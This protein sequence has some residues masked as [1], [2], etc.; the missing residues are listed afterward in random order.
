MT[1][2]AVRDF[3][4]ERGISAEV[5]AAFSIQPNGSGWTWKTSLWDGGEG[6]R[7]KN[8]LSQRPEG[9]QTWKKYKWLPS[10]PG[11]AI[12]LYPP[13]RSLKE[14]ISRGGGR[15]YLPG[16]EVGVMSFMSAGTWNATSLF[17]DNTIPPNLPNLLRELGVRTLILIPDRD[18]SGET[19]AAKIRDLL[20]PCFDIELEVRALPY[21]FEAKHGL[22]TNDLWL[23]VLDTTPEDDDPAGLFM[24]RIADLPDWRLPEPEPEAPAPNRSFLGDDELELPE[25]FIADIEDKLGIEHGFKTT[26]WSKRLVR[27]P[28]HDDANPSASWNHYIGVLKC[29]STCGRTYLAKEVGDKFG[30]QLRS[31]LPVAPHI[32]LAKDAPPPAAA[33]SAPAQPA[34]AAS[35]SNQLTLKRGLRPPLPP[36]AALTDAEL[37]LAATGRG[38]L[39]SYMAFALAAA[40]A[41]PAIFHEA[42]GLWL[43]SAI[44]TRRVALEAQ[45]APLFPNLYILIVART[46]LYRKSTAMNQAERVLREAGLDYL[47]LPTEFSTEALF[48]T[49]AGLRHTNESELPRDVRIRESKGRFFAAQRS[50]LV[51]EA[52]SIFALAKRDYGSGLHEMLLKGYDAPAYWSKSLKTRGL[53]VVRRPCMAFMGATTPIMMSRYFGNEEAESGLAPRFVFITPDGPPIPPVWTDAIAVPFELSARL[54]RLHQLLPFYQSSRLSEDDLL[55]LDPPDEVPPVLPAIFEPHARERMERYVRVVGFDLAQHE[56]DQ[57]GAV[58]GRLVVTAKKVATLLAFGELTEKTDRLVISEAN[59]L[60]AIV[61]VE[62]WRE[63]YHRLSGDVAR[64]SSSKLDEKV[65]RY[66]ADAGRE[67]RTARDISRDCGMKDR[68]QLEDVLTLLA[69]D[70]K[71][72]KYSRPAQ[73]RGSRATTAFRL[74]EQNAEVSS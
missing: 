13:G 59:V 21:P 49:L 7:W 12:F 69:E 11:G 19:W 65:L 38:F 23:E 52:S 68:R 35:S 6:T 5:V 17:G 34:P 1:Q 18:E 15:L 2:A 61:I 53:V 30:L 31:Y 20:I 36:A 45:H 60:A 32:P 43:L 41:A 63:S 22:D 25:K 16:G 70:G 14:E 10:M 67:G 42:L 46:T 57:A 66:L 44:S 73:G 71:V 50:F 8:Y 27:C 74:V 28:F 3:A 40:P 39:D 64:A 58:Y 51:D 55:D 47:L 72:E 56:T 4:M 26:G 24:A 29:F 48:D 54:R 9:D 62:R 37:A 33:V